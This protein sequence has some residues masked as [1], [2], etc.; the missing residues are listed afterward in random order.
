MPTTNLPIDGGPVGVTPSLPS[1]ITVSN[2]LQQALALILGYW[3]GQRLPLR[4][5]PSGVLRIADSPL[6]DVYQLTAGG[7]TATFQGD[8]KPA[9]TVLVLAHPDNAGRVWVRV[10]ATAT[11]TNAFPLAA[12]EGI[13]FS[14]CDLSDL[15]V[16]IATVGEKAIVGYTL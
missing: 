11:T 14:V 3:Q 10:R 7:A 13:A 6:V 4:C 15:N 8:V 2:E 1:Q 9:S 12:G 5:S 16:M